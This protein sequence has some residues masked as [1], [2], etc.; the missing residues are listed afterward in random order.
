M[1]PAQAGQT[2]WL[3]FI[4]INNIELLKHA[5][6]PYS[7]HELV[8]KIFSAANNDPKS[9][10]TATIFIASQI[11]HYSST[12]LHSNQIYLVI[13]KDFV[14]PFQQKPLGLFS[15]FRQIM[16]NNPN[17]VLDK[18]TAFLAYCLLDRIVAD[19]FIVLEDY[20]NRV[21]AIDNA[22]F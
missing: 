17:R 8:M 10:I 4:G 14:L 9:K 3:H 5:L 15:Q 20:N 1:L 22:L 7:I 16:G 2:N 13:G 11:Y 19:Y 6:E 12:K 18:N 21:E